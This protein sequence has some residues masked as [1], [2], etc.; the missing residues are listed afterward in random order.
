MRRGKRKECEIL[1]PEIDEL[2]GR[3][4]AAVPQLQN[5]PRLWQITLDPEGPPRR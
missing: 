2:Q 4:G 3:L 1:H 5:P